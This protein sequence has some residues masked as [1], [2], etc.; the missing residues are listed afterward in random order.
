MDVSIGQMRHVIKFER[1]TGAHTGTGGTTDNHTELLTTRGSFVQITGGN[2][3][4]DAGETIW[5][6]RYESYVFMQQALDNELMKSLRVLVR[7]RLLSI[8]SYEIVNQQDFLY[9]FIL[10]ESE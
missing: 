7:N 3:I 1:F 10:T 5:F 4:L 6:K 8:E 9:K 2:R